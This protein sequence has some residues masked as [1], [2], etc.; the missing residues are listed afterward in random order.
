MNL[1]YYLDKWII[2]LVATYKTKILVEDSIEIFLLRIEGKCQEKIFK[3]VLNFL[4]S[5]IKL[6]ILEG[7]S[8]LTM[9][10]E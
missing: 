6:S 9:T 1:K 3:V 4:L 7:R 2:I 10:P 5:R 8:L